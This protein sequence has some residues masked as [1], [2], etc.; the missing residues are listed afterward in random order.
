MH[1][2]RCDPS[3]ISSIRPE[4]INPKSQIL[5]PSSLHFYSIRPELINKLTLGTLR[6]ALEEREKGGDSV[7]LS[8]LAA[9]LH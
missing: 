4:L 1:D 3:N 2:K 5:N 9:S 8:E 6:A 7:V